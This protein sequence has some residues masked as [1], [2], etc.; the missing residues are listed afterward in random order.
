MSLPN[1]SDA[2]VSIRLDLGRTSLTMCEYALPSDEVCAL[3]AVLDDVIAQVVKSWPR[4]VY[5]DHINARQRRRRGPDRKAQ[6]MPLMN[7]PG[8]RCGDSLPAVTDKV[9]KEGR[10]DDDLGEASNGGHSPDDSTNSRQ[11]LLA[12]RV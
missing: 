9:F 1:Q 3:A 10:L 7:V 6:V 12:A 2:S 11:L 8:W 5:W 4:I